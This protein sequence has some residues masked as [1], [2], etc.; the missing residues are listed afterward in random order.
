MA[1]ETTPLTDELSSAQ[2]GQVPDLQV[3]QA[4]GC[5]ADQLT[6][7][8]GIDARRFDDL[9]DE[10]YKNFEELFIAAQKAGAII[11]ANI[12][13]VKS[14]FAEY[15]AFVRTE[16]QKY[17]PVKNIQGAREIAYLY[18]VFFSRVMNMTQKLFLKHQKTEVF[19]SKI[20]VLVYAMQKKLGGFFPE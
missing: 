2:K 9:H 4:I 8:L 12:P 20:R 3:S 10:F 13:G 6:R 19:R 17:L 7:E 16:A 5:V 18:E 1:L 15:S 14:K 11:K